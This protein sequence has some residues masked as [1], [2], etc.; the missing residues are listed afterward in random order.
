MDKQYIK[1][2]DKAF[3][4]YLNK[5]TEIHGFNCGNCKQA[6]LHSLICSKGRFEILESGFCSIFKRK[7]EK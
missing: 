3:K 1:M 7:E 4:K 2:S 6:D 5:I